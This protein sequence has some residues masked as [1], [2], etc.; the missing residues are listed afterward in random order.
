MYKAFLDKFL[1]SFK[2]VLPV[3]L[4]LIIVIITK[5]SYIYYFHIP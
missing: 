4:V 3:T 5:E 1:E 2:S